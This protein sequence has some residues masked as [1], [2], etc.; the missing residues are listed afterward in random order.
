MTSSKSKLFKKELD[1]NMAAERIVQ[2]KES[3]IECSIDQHTINI[4]IGTQKEKGAKPD[5]GNFAGHHSICF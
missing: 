4:R 3:G 2:L 5:Y 1:I